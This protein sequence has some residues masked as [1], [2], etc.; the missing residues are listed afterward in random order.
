MIEYRYKCTN[1]NNEFDIRMS[2]KDKPLKKCN[3]CKQS[4]LERVIF[5]P[6]GFVRQEVKTVGQLAERN[7]KKLG[8][9]EIQ[10]REL[11]N[12]DQTK[13]AMDQARKELNSKIAK[14]N[15]AQKTKYIE[16]GKI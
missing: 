12:K 10:E 6:Q 5:S 3:E 2:I 1:C 15:E 7:A 11:K 9:N 14:M 4:T 13:L 8:K 16:E